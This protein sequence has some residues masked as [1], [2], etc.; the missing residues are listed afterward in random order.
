[1]KNIGLLLVAV[2]FVFASCNKQKRTMK[3]LTGNWNIEQSDKKQI[4]SSGSEN[5][6]ESISNC[7]DLVISDI[8]KDSSEVKN[9]AFT[10]IDSAGDTIKVSNKL[11]TDDKNRRIIFKNALCDS[12]PE[13]DLI[14][15]VDKS[16][17]NKQIWTAYGIDGTYFYPSNNNNPNDASSWLMW[18][19]TLKRAD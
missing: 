16:K 8:S 4:L 18:Q 6:I 1:M 11:Y 7:G 10:F 17:R 15:T 5:T 12:T 13:C 3:G 19:I 9:Y 2:A 14:W